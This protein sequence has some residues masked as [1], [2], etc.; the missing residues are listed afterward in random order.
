VVEEMKGRARLCSIAVD[1]ALK[2][3]SYLLGE[4][5]TAADVMMG[6]SVMIAQRY[7][8]IDGLPNLNAYW[9]RLSSRP[10]YLR[11]AAA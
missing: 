2:D 5:F 9:E 11:A 3:R 7:A 4:E 6:Y 8:S 1:Q 10:A